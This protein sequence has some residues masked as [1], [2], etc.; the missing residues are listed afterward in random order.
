MIQ[1]ISWIFQ[2]CQRGGIGRRSGFKIH[3]GQLR[4]GSTPAVGT[5]YIINV[6]KDTAETPDTTGFLLSLFLIKI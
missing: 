3:R 6:Y 2:S 1:F 5:N 4:A